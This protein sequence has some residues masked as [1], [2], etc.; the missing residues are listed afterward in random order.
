VTNPLDRWYLTD[1]LGG[2]RRFAVAITALNVLGHSVLGFEQSW[3]QPAAS[4]AAAYLTEL[5]LE[6]AEARAGKRRPKFAGDVRRFVDFLL[7]AHISGLAVAMLLYTNERIWPT[8]LASVIA[9]D[10]TFLIP[11]TWG[12]HRSC[13]FFLGSG[14]RRPTTSPRTCEVPETG[15]YRRSL[16]AVAR[17]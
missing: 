4:V 9:I 15:S 16:S 12:S 8:V 14:L 10:S 6:W 7:P 11:Q 17:F 1:R 13:S 5:I 2:L 3:A